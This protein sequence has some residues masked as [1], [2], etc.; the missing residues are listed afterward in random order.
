MR[1]MGKSVRKKMWKR[2]LQANSK[3]LYVFVLL[4]GLFFYPPWVG[5]NLKER[6][7]RNC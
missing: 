7:G 6:V 4:S 5:V 2:L 3:L 1:E